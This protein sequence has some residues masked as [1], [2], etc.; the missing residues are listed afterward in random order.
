MELQSGVKRIKNNQTEEKNIEE[1]SKEQ[2]QSAE[3]V[4]LFFDRSVF[5]KK[6]APKVKKVDVPK[7]NPE[8]YK[9]I[10]EWQAEGGKRAVKLKN[11]RT[12]QEYIVT[13]GDTN[14]DVILEERNLLYY[15]FKINGQVI[16][17]NR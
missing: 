7:V 15:K 12:G 17:I 11:I 4:Y 10:V 13:E 6:P 8:D 1:E 9:A 14:G 16:R 2:V 3:F 5:Q